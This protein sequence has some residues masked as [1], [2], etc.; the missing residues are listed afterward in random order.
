MLLRRLVFALFLLLLSA[1]PALAEPADIAAASRGVVRVVII[2]SDGTS[3]SLIGHGTGFAVAPNLVVTNAHVVEALRQD[4]SLIAGVVPPEGRA[5]VQARVVAFSPGND[6]A[7]LRIDGKGMLPAA[8]L[9]PGAVQ[10]GAEVFAVGYPGNVDLAQGLSMADLV[11]PQTAVKTRGYVS[12]GRSS[13]QF[14]TILHTA[15]LGSG[16]SGGPLLD[17]C[18]RVVGVN[19][20]GTVSDNGTDSAFY[21]AISMRELASFL[22]QAGVEAHT[23]GLPCTSIADL[24]RAESERAAGEQSRLAAEKEAR[25]AAHDRASDKAQRE[26]ERAVLSERDNGMALA[27]LLLVAALGAGGWAFLQAQR[28]NDRGMKIAG[29]LA[30]ALV[31]GA[32]LAWMLRPSLASIDE[33]AKDMLAEP[34]ASA[35]AEPSP[36]ASGAGRMTCVIDTSRS[37]VTVSDITD[38]PL[39]WSADGCVNGRTQYGLAQD[40]WSRV[41]VPASEETISVTHYD[42]ASRSYTVERFLMGLDAMTRARAERQKIVAPACGSGEDETRRFGAAQQAI[43][44]LLPSEPNERMRYNCQPTP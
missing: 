1:P 9:Y 28:G 10:D 12:G 38:V 32:V 15:P 44:A 22:R 41:L 34:E 4:D 18:G 36:L 42:P 6:L 37:R 39:E 11:N 26:A 16:N 25:S 8:T 30:G 7:L 21:F 20:F 31:L 13:R 35:S 27:A 2:Q 24:D 43:K 23:S 3:A 29:A 33:R 14:D 19:S 5:G 40:G 17:S